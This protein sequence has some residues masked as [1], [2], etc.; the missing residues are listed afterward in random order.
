MAS[1]AFD[2]VIVG[3][4]LSGLVL[5]SRL[6]ENRDTTVL[7]IES[8]KDLRDD[9]RVKIPAMWAMLIDDPDATWRLKTVPQEA[10]GGR[11]I[12][13]AQGRTVGGSS[14]LN[15]LSF[16]ATSK[17]NVDAW[18]SLGNPEWDWENFTR[19]MD[20]SYKNGPLQLALPDEDTK[21]PQAWRDTLSSL[22]FSTSNEPF[23]GHVS[24]A[25]T[26]PDTISASKE[27]SFSGNA[28]LGSANDRPNVTIWTETNVEKILFEASDN[29][30]IASGVEYTTFDGQTKTVKAV[31]EVILTAGTVNSPRILEL[32][33]VGD[34]T[35][36]ERL[37]IKVHID[38][39]FV[40]ENLQNH[41]MCGVNFEVLGGEKGF[42]TMDNL[43]RQDAR[44]V[45]TAMDDYTKR[46]RGPFSRSGANYAAHL[47]FPGIGDTTGTEN[48]NK[49]LQIPVPGDSSKNT[50]PPFAKAHESFVH[51]VLKSPSEASGC[52]LSAAA[53]AGFNPDG[54]KAS[55]TQ[56]PGDKGYFTIVLLLAHPLSRG[57]VHVK[58]A[59]PSVSP[60]HLA[61]DPAYLTHP[62]DIEV[63]ARH[64]Q[65]AA[66]T[67]AATEPLASHLKPEGEGEHNP[68]APDVGSFKDL[69][70]VKR[71]VR[72]TVVGAQHWTGT[73]S[74]MSRDMGGVVDPKLRLY[75]CRNLRVC[76]AS[77][78]PITP[79]TNP[80]ATV[81]GIAERAADIIKA[82]YAVGG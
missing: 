51:S 45:A 50:A 17:A 10:L 75:G 57:S 78:I 58:S 2:F 48:L 4:G 15:G 70:N 20:K 44:A 31:K 37:G 65:Y 8:G 35:R 26:V 47:P 42:E 54:S 46:Q 41:P 68:G 30:T 74:M 9:P 16:S 1:E 77:V 56:F 6:S 5:A 25:L 79:R 11:E 72:E 40:G 52:Y 29:D 33:G 55:I 80:Q 69:D 36:L 49:I 39:R 24:G 18:A 27:R 67:I 81:Y 82:E 53:F 32:S 3:G 21:W 38:N 23:S 60:A 61:V 12:V 64:L 62:L 63:L 71:Y 22:G 13:F 7:V 43:A 34:K 66:A 76:D 19:S 28:Y 59:T 14:A 73:C